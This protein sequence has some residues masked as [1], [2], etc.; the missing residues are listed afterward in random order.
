MRSRCNGY[1]SY[2]LV[3]K[4]GYDIGMLHEGYDE[5]IIRMM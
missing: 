2:V 1:I 3:N 4:S 5:K